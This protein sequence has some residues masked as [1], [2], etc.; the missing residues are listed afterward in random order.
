MLEL[1]KVTHG[2]EDEK[3][4]ICLP[5]YSCYPKPATCTPDIPCIP[6]SLCSPSIYCYPYTY[7]CYP[8]TVISPISP[9]DISI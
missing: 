1:T 7:I 6:N 8:K 9:G 5:C 2:K 4:H 3:A